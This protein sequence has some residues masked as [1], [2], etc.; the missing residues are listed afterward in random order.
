MGKLLTDTLE[1]ALDLVEVLVVACV[2]GVER[3]QV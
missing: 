3:R 2:G 1:G